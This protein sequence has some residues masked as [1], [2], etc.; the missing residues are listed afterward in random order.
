M[1]GFLTGARSAYDK[2]DALTFKPPFL[3]LSYGFLKQ[4][5][6]TVFMRWLNESF[7][8]AQHQAFE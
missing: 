4:N 6:D 5:T 1:L 7:T 3:T 2:T 8:V